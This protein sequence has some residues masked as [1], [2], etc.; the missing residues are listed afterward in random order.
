M[1]GRGTVDGSEAALGAGLEPLRVTPDGMVAAELAGAVA[2]D[3]LE[4]LATVAAVSPYLKHLMLAD[5]RRLEAVL[6]APLSA[7]VAEAVALA[8]RDEGDAGPALRRAKGRVALAVALA[9]LLCGAD[10]ATVT[11]A[12]SD[13]ADAAVAAALAAVLRDLGRT[14][15]TTAQEGCGLFILALGK[16]GGQELNYS[17]DVDLVA[18]YDPELAEAAGI[19]PKLAVR[20]VQRTS[21]LLHERTADGYVFRVDLRL[22]PDPAA[23][24]VAVST[25]AA[26]Q[27]FHGRARAWERQAMIKARMVAGDLRAARAYL[28]ALD[29]TVWRATYDFS[30]IDDTLEM[31]GLIAAVRGAGA[32]TVPG[33]NVKSGRGGI[34]EIEFL[35]QTLQRIAGGRDRRLRG[36]QTVPMLAQLAATGWVDE[37]LQADLAAAYE[38]LRRVEHRLQ[39]VADQQTH[40]LPEPDG[41][42]RI[43][44]MMR[45][46]DFPRSMLATLETV[47][48]HFATLPELVGRCNPMLAA[49]GAAG[50]LPDAA[51]A[52]F[53]AAFVRWR[54]G[55]YQ[56]FRTDRAKRLLDALRD[57]LAAAIGAAAEPEATLAELDGFFARL[58][59]GIEL[60][61]RLDAHRE[62]VPVL[63]LIAGAAPR[64][65]HELAR[66]SHLL[67]VLIDPT[68]FGRL[69]DEGELGAAL[70]ATLATAPDYEDRLDAMR[71]F[72]Q[73]QALLVDVRVLTG[74]A[75]GPEA[76]Q[77]LTRL[78]DAT[79]TRALSV[80]TEAFAA[81]HGRLAGGAAVLL[82]LGKFGSREMTA[83][84]DLDMV[85]LYDCAADAGQS[86]G[87]KP[88]SPGHYYTR[89]AQR[90]IAAL[91]AQTARG[92]LYAVDLRLRPSGRAGP[93]ATHVRSF[94]RYHAGSAWVWEQMAF[95]RARIVAGD[96]P[97][98]ERALGAVRQALAAPRDRAVLAADVAGMRGKMA[99]QSEAGLKLMPGGQVD[100]EFVAQF[101][102]L[103][104]GLLR[105]GDDTSTAAALA[106]ARDA[107]VLPEGGYETLASASA[108]YQRLSQLL[109]VASAGAMRID[110]APVALQQL[111]VR[112]G[113]AP[114]LAFLVA[115]LALRQRAVRGEFVRLVG[116]VEATEA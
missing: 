57:A 97:L 33:H 27:Y 20:I 83:T 37:R 73:E 13:T 87:A 64:L 61:A 48:G 98:G 4:A 24:P 56:A 53:E 8:A 106:R 96:R 21:R 80:A 9:D 51:A 107:G 94:E 90:V 65:S 99:A 111:L 86:D 30:A 92:S 85:F 109:A 75:S 59:R 5:L 100:V 25:R 40:T 74:S 70:D 28:A 47:H 95:S 60:L 102:T 103:A 101:L 36:R 62:L 19:D 14:G 104:H 31:R 7:T 114:D 10:V 76:S 67:D 79:V 11:L 115:D 68:F 34:R 66:R 1:P 84:S 15:V 18:L 91:S 43:A 39:M 110:D 23:T 22:R 49:I 71:T 69:P 2:Q 42:V 16:L 12:L 6:A 52:A 29:P 58:P 112:A 77:A 105:V 88:L 55:P 81:R 45:D 82:G 50:P 78:A 3:A 93:I 89:L 32:I 44:A 72:G 38:T 46:D 113:E 108:L 63:V 41:L 17:S 35:V 26:L 116:P 54:E